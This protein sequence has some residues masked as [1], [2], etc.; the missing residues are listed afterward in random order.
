MQDFIQDIKQDQIPSEE[1]KIVLYTLAESVAG[2]SCK[3]L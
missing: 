3:F 2:P 1:Q